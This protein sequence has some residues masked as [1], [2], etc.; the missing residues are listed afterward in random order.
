[1]E[2]KWRLKIVVD[3]EKYSRETIDKGV[4][5]DKHGAIHGFDLETPMIMKYGVTILRED[6]NTGSFYPFSQI[7]AVH[8]IITEEEV[9]DAPS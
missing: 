3:L 9:E 7:N 8:Y 5:N 1:M 4:F 2:K 6:S